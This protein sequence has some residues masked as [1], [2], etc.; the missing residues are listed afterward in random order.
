MYRAWLGIF[1]AVLVTGCGVTHRTVAERTDQLPRRAT[2][3]DAEVSRS[4]RRSIMQ[5]EMMSVEARNL[6]I[7]TN[8]GLITL[9]GAVDSEAERAKVRQLAELANDGG[10]INDGMSV[11][12]EAVASKFSGDPTKTAA[13]DGAS[14]E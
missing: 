14:F 13:K 5:N 3:A 4:V 11:I 12:P 10:Q 1:V 2:N 7:Y 9:R 6:Y 8:N